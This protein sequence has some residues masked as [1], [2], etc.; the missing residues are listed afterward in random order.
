MG[1]SFI[2]ISLLLALAATAGTLAFGLFALLKGGE[3]NR[4][5]GNRAMQGR[6]LL[7][8][9]ALVLFILMLTFGR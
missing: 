9:I 4:Q 7:Q 2:F 3:F 1:Q 5:Y 8:A 6:I